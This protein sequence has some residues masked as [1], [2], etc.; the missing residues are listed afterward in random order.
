MNRKLIVADSY[1]KY[2]Y[3]CK[4]NRMSSRDCIF[5]SSTDEK[6]LY[7]IAGLRMN[8][9]D[10]IFLDAPFHALRARIEAMVT[11][12]ESV[13]AAGYV[14][15]CFIRVREGETIF[16]I[17]TNGV[18]HPRLDGYSIVPLEDSHDWVS[19]IVD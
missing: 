16:H 12:S 17:D 7:K 8:R 19:N 1:I 5:L 14:K 2:E 11:F 10:V 4:E 9:E 3:F 15:N 13:T 18:I 6:S